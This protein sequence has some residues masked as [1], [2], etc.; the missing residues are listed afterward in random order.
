MIA[1]TP[2]QCVGAAA[3]G[4]LTIAVISQ[5]VCCFWSDAS[6]S[7]KMLTMLEYIKQRAVTDLRSEIMSNGSSGF[8]LVFAM[9]IL[10]S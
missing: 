1:K 6:S 4:L 3:I 10:A 7:K 8:S 5:S 2:A 9:S